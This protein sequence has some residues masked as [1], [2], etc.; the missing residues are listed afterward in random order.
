MHQ[1]VVPSPS[2][3]ELAAHVGLKRR[4]FVVSACVL[5]LSLGTHPLLF[6]GFI[7][8]VIVVHVLWAAVLVGTAAGMGTRW[9]TVQRA[10]VVTGVASMVALVLD[11]HFTGGLSSTLFP[12][13]FA[14]PLIIA[15]FTPGDVVTVWASVVLTLVGM[16]VA[17][18][19][20]DVSEQRL[21]GQV[22]LFFFLAWVAVFS[23]KQFRR[24]RDTERDAVHARL[25]ALEQL[26]RSEHLRADA[27]RSQ[28]EMERLA[29]VGRLAAGVAHEVNNPLA[30]VKSNLGYLEEVSGESV[31]DLEDMRRVLWETQQG[32]LRIEQ[33]VTDLRRFSRDSSDAEEAGSVAE[34]LDEAERL[35]SVRLRSLGQ[36]VREVE[37]H[38]V[39]VR[40]GQRQLV[41]VV[42][43][44]LLNAADALDGVQPSRA[45][46]IVLRATRVEGG[47][48]LE[49]ED[50][51]PGVPET[52]LPHL[53]EPFFTTKAPGKGTGL[54]LALCREYLARV[55]GTLTVANCPDGGACFTLHLPAHPE[56]KPPG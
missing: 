39:R 50:N 15:V 30:Y 51:G 1:P 6:G 43:N 7:P 22:T 32:V 4:G 45:A 42:L 56:K 16:L 31:Q 11:I 55:G 19:H 44:L 12:L 3:S 26:A 29:L 36:V 8:A 9:L 14:M 33:I 17:S 27:V 53:F 34:A 24:M 49:V 41:Q 13:L 52:V 54:G 21:V 25:A 40:L 48:R 2:P 46:R 5:L 37:P 23:C 20:S 10:S 38:L 18:W 47:V 28:A 35:A